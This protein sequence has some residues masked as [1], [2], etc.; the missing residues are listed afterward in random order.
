MRI[1]YIYIKQP[2]IVRAPLCSVMGW[3][4]SLETIQNF[5]KINLVLKKYLTSFRVEPHFVHFV[6]LCQWVGL[7]RWKPFKTQIRLVSKEIF[8][9]INLKSLGTNFVHFTVFELAS[10]V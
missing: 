10:L 1:I 7:S 2:H 3:R 4:R 8:N 6:V 5:K 9:K